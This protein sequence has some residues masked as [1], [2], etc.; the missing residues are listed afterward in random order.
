MLVFNYKK[1]ISLFI[2]IALFFCFF[3]P[4]VYAQD[5]DGDGILDSD[6]PFPNGDPVNPPPTIKVPPNIT[7]PDPAVNTNEG[8]NQLPNTNSTGSTK[9]NYVLLEP[10]G[11]FT[12]FNTTD[13]CPF[14]V[15][16]NKVIEIFLGICAVLAMLMII[17]GGFKYITSEL[18]SFKQDGKEEITNALIG[19]VIALA[20]YALLNTLNPKLLNLCPQIPQAVLNTV[21]PNSIF[22]KETTPGNIARCTEITDPNH[23]CNPQNLAKYFGNKANAMSKICNVESGGNSNAESG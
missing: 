3:V 7:A 9:T 1:I 19:F 2:V 15:Y 11:D 17:M 14:V 13:S 6:D 5:A 23:P 16:L 12:A 22:D 20:A 10:I 4:P 21:E 8:G 18:P